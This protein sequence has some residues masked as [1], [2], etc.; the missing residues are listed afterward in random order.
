MRRDASRF[1][2]ALLDADA[3]ARAHA[4]AFIARKVASPCAMSLPA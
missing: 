3:W 2:D 4:C 1:L